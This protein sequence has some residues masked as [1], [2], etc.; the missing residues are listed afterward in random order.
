MRI[1]ELA[2]QC[3]TS[4]VVIK[5]L[6]AVELIPDPRRGFSGQREYDDVD[7]VRLQ[8]ILI[9]RELGYSISEIR[10]LLGRFC[11]YEVPCRCLLD[12]I[13]KQIR[14]LALVIGKLQS[15]GQ[16]LQRLRTTEAN[17]F[18]ESSG[19][20]CSYHQTDNPPVQERNVDP[21]KLITTDGNGG[22]NIKDKDILL[23]S[24]TQ[25]GLSNFE[26]AENL[27]LKYAT[28]RNRFAHIY[29]K[30]NVSDKVGALVKAR[31]MGLIE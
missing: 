10:E 2:R 14:T 12:L 1:G 6:E 5:H 19:S 23:L 8:T 28:I 3:N 18:A 20:F 4:S 11:T 7:L 27:N 21:R 26:I 17:A 9:F 25:Q 31:E 15:A 13:E 24:L 16:D 22:V 29:E 30:L